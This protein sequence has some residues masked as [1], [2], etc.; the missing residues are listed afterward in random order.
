MSETNVSVHPLVSG[1]L[2]KP[3]N[4]PFKEGREDMEGW[5]IWRLNPDWPTHEY[6]V[7]EV[8]GGIMVDSEPMDNHGAEWR[9]TE[10]K[11]YGE[12]FGP[13]LLR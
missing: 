1:I 4:L 6:K 8:T 2:G 3:E 9:V 10:D 5:Y 13:V 7:V 11:L 12:F